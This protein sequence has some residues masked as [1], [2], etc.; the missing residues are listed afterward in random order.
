MCVRHKPLARAWATCSGADI[1]SNVG[2]ILRK[3]VDYERG[4]PHYLLLCAST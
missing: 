3:H 1:K 4:R 2:A